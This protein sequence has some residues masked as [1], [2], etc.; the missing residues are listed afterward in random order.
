MVIFCITVGYSDAGRIFTGFD[1]GDATVY[2]GDL[3]GGDG[4]IQSNVEC[5]IVGD[6]GVVDKPVGVEY[7][8]VSVHALMQLTLGAE[9]IDAGGQRRH[10]EDRGLYAQQVAANAHT[11]EEPRESAADT[12]MCSLA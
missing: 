7:D 12:W 6:C 5:G 2:G 1:A 9:A 8:K 3:P 10:F 11:T 4:V